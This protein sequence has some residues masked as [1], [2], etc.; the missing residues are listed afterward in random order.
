MS[1]FVKVCGLT[2]PD[3]VDAAVEAGVDAIGLVLSPSP[4]RVSAR[5]AERLLDRIPGSVERIAVVSRPGPGELRAIAA[6]SWDGVQLDAGVADDAL[7]PPRAFLLPSFRGD[8]NGVRRIGNFTRFLAPPP[9]PAPLD[10]VSPRWVR[11]RDGKRSTAAPPH[12]LRGAFLLDGPI[13]GG[14]GVAVERGLARIAARLGR[15][16]LAGGL[17]PENVADAIRD[18]RPFGVDVSS[19]VES[20]PGVKSPERIRRF[21]AAVRSADAC[22]S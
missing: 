15:L 13:G 6:L 4:R 19:G 22:A 9:N 8:A 20:S 14:R 11:A 3:A 2:T 10:S 21:L 1:V 7:L 17:R 16:V 5:T 18:V 12:S